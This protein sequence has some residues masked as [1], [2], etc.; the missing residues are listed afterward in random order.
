MVDRQAAAAQT[1]G[2]GLCQVCWK[3]TGPRGRATLARS[4]SGR[5]RAAWCIQT[6]GM[7]LFL[8][9]RA[10]E[11]FA[12]LGLAEVCWLWAEH[13]VV[14]SVDSKHGTVG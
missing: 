1:A 8:R 7:Q 11:M 13:R 12:G 6:D 10:V 4:G 2:S 3:E 14:S 9:E 5:G